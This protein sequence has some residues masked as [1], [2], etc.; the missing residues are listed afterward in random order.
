MKSF[1]KRAALLGLAALAAASLTGCAGSGPSARENAIFVV[2]AEAGAEYNLA[3]VRRGELSLTESVR[4][5]YFAARAQSYG[6]GTSGI[7]YENFQVSVGDSVKAGDVLATLESAEIDREMDALTA[8]AEALTLARDRNQALLSLYDAR[9]SG[10]GD[11]PPQSDPRRRGY[12]VAIRAA[13]DRMEVLS[14]RL[15]EL[16]DQRAGRVLTAEIDGTVTFVRAVQPGELSVKGRTIVTVTDLS[17]CAFEATVERPEAISFDET[18]TIKIDGQDYAIL[19]TT[20]EALGIEPAPMNEKSARSRVYFAPLVPSVNLAEGATGKFT[21]VIEAAQDAL[22]VPAAA[23]AVVDGQTCVYV[24]GAAGLRT[25]CPVAVGLETPRSCEIL[26]GLQ[27]G[28]RVI[29]N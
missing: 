26:S 24:P 12:E 2:R 14:V 20:P 22:Y 1:K 21:V 19:R 18:Y 10:R 11:A 5:T 27:E 4:V 29:V 23:I 28:D 7:Y 16:S 6:F 3:N 13:E 9:L 15:S 17:S 8:E 25:I